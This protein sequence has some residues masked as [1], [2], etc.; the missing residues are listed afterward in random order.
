MIN[1]LTRMIPVNN[2]QWETC[3]HHSDCFNRGAQRIDREQVTGDNRSPLSPSALD[4]A[5]SPIWPVVFENFEQVSLSSVAEKVQHLLPSYC[6]LDRNSPRLLKD[7]FNTL[8]P[9]IVDLIKPSL[10]SR[11]VPAAFKHAAIQPLIKKNNLD[12]SILSNFRPIIQAPI[13]IKGYRE[14]TLSPTAVI[15]WLKW[16]FWEVPVWF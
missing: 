8:G 12:P 13:Y 3:C 11:S 7:V 14:G 16:Y 6:P 9:C 2:P 15:P 1:I 10:M 5:P 4:P